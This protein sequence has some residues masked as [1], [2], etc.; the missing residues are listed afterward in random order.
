MNPRTPA[1]ELIAQTLANAL[2]GH[3]S[4]GPLDVMRLASAAREVET[5]RIAG[6]ALTVV[7]RNGAGTPITSGV[8]ISPASW[9]R[10]TICP[11]RS[12]TAG[13]ARYPGNWIGSGSSSE[14]IA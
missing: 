11:A 9:R 12:T 6:L 3:L 7:H 5:H 1:E 10:N 13:S 14:P 4:L 2:R 8:R